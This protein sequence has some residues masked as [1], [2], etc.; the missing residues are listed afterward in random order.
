MSKTTSLTV[1]APGSS[2]LHV[3]RRDRPGWIPDE[4]GDNWDPNPYAYQT[5]EDLMPAGRFH[6]LY[7]KLLAQLLDPYLERLGLYQLFDVFLFYRDWEG[8]KQRIA[9]DVL[10]APVFIELDDEL[11]AHS[12]DLDVEPV[13]LC[14]IE[15]TSPESVEQDTQRKPLL[16]AR[17][18]IKEYLL[19]DL[20]NAQDR[21]RK[22]IGITLWR[23]DGNAYIVVQPD[24]EGYVTL[25]TLGLRLRAEG[26]RLVFQVLATG[27]VLH[28]SAELIATIEANEQR[29]EQAE[30]A[31]IQAEQRAAAEAAA[32][33][34]VEDELAR[35]RAE[36]ERLRGSQG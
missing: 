3:D 18:G 14:V 27:E 30:Q 16:Y 29:I 10:I 32:R 31:R 17:F 9:P 12:Y 36:L 1:T 13:P 35:L 5:E 26:R 19:L 6:S 21:L 11:A 34:Q 33:Q 22:Q 28:T 4:V 15:L 24:D 2:G 23:L 7:F 8:R 20:L 25:E